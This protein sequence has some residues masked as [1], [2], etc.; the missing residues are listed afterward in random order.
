M[1][2]FKI[3]AYAIINLALKVRLC[4]F[5]LNIF[6]KQ[7]FFFRFLVHAIKIKDLIII[8]LFNNT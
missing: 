1:F 5:G 4:F 6:Q 8:Q 2:Y 7:R 3:L